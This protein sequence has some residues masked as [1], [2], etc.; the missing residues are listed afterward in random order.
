MRKL[1]V[2]LLA[3]LLAL[4]MV[5]VAWALDSNIPVT[6][7]VDKTDLG[8]ADITVSPASLD[9]H[10]PSGQYKDTKTVTI[11]S[12][13]TGNV[14]LD[15]KFV[16]SS[17]SPFTTSI[18]P[19]LK[20]ANGNPIW[21]SMSMDDNRYSFELDLKPDSPAWKTPPPACDPG[22]Q[23]YLSDH[24]RREAQGMLTAVSPVLKP[25]SGSTPTTID[26]PVT[27][28]CGL[29]RSSN[30]TASGTMTFTFTLVP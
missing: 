21:T 18:A 13:S 2:A 7:T 1:Q 12:N 5:G 24:L 15:G 14:Q 6:A 19:S 30:K 11:T 17:T 23:Y 29:L 16:M 20:D 9:F 26:I 22:K 3:M 4:N 25:A 27:F 8:T 10:V 28:Y